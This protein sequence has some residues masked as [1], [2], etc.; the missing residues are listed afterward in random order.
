MA[1]NSGGLSMG[2]TA[3]HIVA[4]KPHIA[5]GCVA[6]R[7][8]QQERSRYEEGY[9]C[10]AVVRSSEDSLPCIQFQPSVKCEQNKLWHQKMDQSHSPVPDYPKSEEAEQN[11]TNC[12]RL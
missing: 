2:N 5:T 1:G 7:A 3:L 8:E 9:V 4:S 10:L 12:F 11:E 6:R